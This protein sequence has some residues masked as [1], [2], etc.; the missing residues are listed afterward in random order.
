MKHFSSFIILML[1]SASTFSQQKSGPPLP[2][3]VSPAGNTYAVIVGIS[4]Y[5]NAG[6]DPLDY[7]HRDAEVFADYLKSKPGGA[8]PGQNIVLLTNEKATE[9]AIYD[10][11][12]WLVETC[13]KDDLVYFYFSVHGDLDIVPFS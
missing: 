1:F 11:L 7:A 5:E 6:I 4:Q 10:A 13:Q 8:V 9:A 2:Q 3:Q 12:Y